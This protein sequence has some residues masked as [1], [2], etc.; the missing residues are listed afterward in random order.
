MNAI[1]TVIE[2]GQKSYFGTNIADGYSYPFVIFSYAERMAKVLNENDPMGT[3]GITEM[4]PLMK[5][6]KDFPENVHGERIFCPISESVFIEYEAEMSHTDYTS[7]NITLNFDERKIGFVF[8]RN[9]PELPAPKIEIR[10][11]RRDARAVFGKENPLIKGTESFYR[12]ELEWSVLE[13]GV[14]SIKIASDKSTGGTSAILPLSD[15]DRNGLMTELETENLDN[16]EVISITAFDSAFNAYSLNGQP[17]SKL[18]ELASELNKLRLDC[19]DNAFN[20]FVKANKISPFCDADSALTAVD[21]IRKNH[22]LRETQD[23]DFR[24]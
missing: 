4:F 12:S 16:C 3:V 2:N 9:C 13:R 20:S 23:M 14:F 1:Y 19:G 17:F 6:N 7:F 5:A 24:M 11:D 18:N 22:A 15:R 10:L 21:G 8:N